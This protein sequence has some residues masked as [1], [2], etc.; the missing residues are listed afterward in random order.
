MSD[1]QINKLFAEITRLHKRLDGFQKNGEIEE[2]NKK[3]K[4]IAAN[5]EAVIQCVRQHGSVIEYMSS[6]LERLELRCPLLKPTGEF[7][8][9]ESAGASDR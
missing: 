7:E 1:A 8:N 9:V 3:L 4:Q 5:G 6:R 2:I